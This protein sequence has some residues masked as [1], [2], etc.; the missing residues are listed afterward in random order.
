MPFYYA[1][2]PLGYIKYIKRN[3]D[4]EGMTMWGLEILFE[5]DL[6]QDT[7]LIHT[8]ILRIEFVIVSKVVEIRRDKVDK[9][10]DTSGVTS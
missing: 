9:A 10:L 8:N 4:Q 3:G 7:C 6:G 5:K 1:Y 2:Y